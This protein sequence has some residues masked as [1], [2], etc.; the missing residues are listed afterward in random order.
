VRRLG[1][2]TDG[3]GVQIGASNQGLR[4]AYTAD[5]VSAGINDVDNGVCIYRSPATDVM[6]DSTLSVAYWHGQG[7]TEDPDGADFFA[8][9]Y[10][11]DG[12]ATWLTLASEGDAELAP[13]WATITAPV[14]AGSSVALRVQCSDGPG[15][16]D[17]V[18]CGIDDVSVCAN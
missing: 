9:E 17:L 4:S 8:L 18:E 13:A 11:L 16:G 6:A 14:P 12:G 3:G 7:A 1:I 5:N 15:V 2:P 10:S